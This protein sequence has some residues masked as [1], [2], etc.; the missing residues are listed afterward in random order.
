MSTT[1]DHYERERRIWSGANQ[2][3]ISLPYRCN[4]MFLL[5]RFGEMERLDSNQHAVLIV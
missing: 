4:A 2:G 3:T 5:Y 1:A